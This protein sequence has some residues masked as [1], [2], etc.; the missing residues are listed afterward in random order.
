VSEFRIPKAFTLFGQRI[1][2]QWSR[3][4]VD[5]SDSVGI[6]KLRKNAIVLQTGDGVEVSRPPSMVEQVFFH[7]IVHWIFHILGEDEFD[8]N[9]KLVDLVGHALH[10]AFTT[11]EFNEEEN[12][13]EV[14]M[15]NQAHPSKR[16][17]NEF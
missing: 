16:Y 11:M 3:T 7:E 17:I 15:Y 12:E 5:D 10:Q 1:E 6:S 2:V 13:H 8:A 14:E 9:E 4:L